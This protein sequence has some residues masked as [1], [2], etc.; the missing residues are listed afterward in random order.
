M[1]DFFDEKVKCRVVV[2]HSTKA[3]PKKIC[4]CNHHAEETISRM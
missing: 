1:D 4:S 3:L 2:G